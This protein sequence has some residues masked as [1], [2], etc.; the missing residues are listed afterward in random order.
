MMVKLMKDNAIANLVLSVLC[1]VAL[2]GITSV[3]VKNV[4][5]P[6]DEPSISIPIVD[7]RQ[8]L[9]TFDLRNDIDDN[10]ALSKSVVSK[11]LNSCNKEQKQVFG[12]LLS[13]DTS[14]VR[15][16]RNS[17]LGLRI[18]STTYQSGSLEISMNDFTYNHAKITAVN[19][20]RLKITPE[21]DGQTIYQKQANGSSYTLN[22][23]ESVML[24]I[25]Y[26]Y[27]Q[28]DVSVS[29]TFEFQETQSD[30]KLSA[31]SGRACFLDIE[32]WTE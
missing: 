27:Y 5:K 19:Y 29:T 4:N 11:F 16:F 9:V 18:G 12:D 24:P 8:N 32:L 1:A 13:S 3:I 30:F 14:C 2:C 28:P 22:N 31:L 7:N 26:N 10:S 23:Q 25:N 6:G 15:L 20:N 21:A 17:E